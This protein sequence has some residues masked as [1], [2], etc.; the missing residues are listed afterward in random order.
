MSFIK[1]LT[2]QNSEHTVNRTVNRT[3]TILMKT[4]HIVNKIKTVYTTH[5]V[6]ITKKMNT[7][8]Q[9]NRS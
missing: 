7:T 5:I 8:N 3:N 2:E 9:V 4:T 1:M 6:N